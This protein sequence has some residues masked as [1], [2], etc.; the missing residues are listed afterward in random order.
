MP[1]PESRQPSADQANP[2]T[3]PTRVLGLFGLAMINIVAI[4]SLRDLPQMASYGIGSIFFY[5]LAALAFF[6]PVS[7]V[8][9]E[10]ATAW[11][12]RGGVYVWVKKAFGIRWGF[13]AV[14]L[15][16]FQNLCWFPVVLTF[17]AASLAYAVA[18]EHSSELAENKLFI[19]AVI[20]AVYWTSV[21][22][23]FFGLS[24]STRICIMGAI[25]GI[26][27]PGL[28]LI[29]L[30]VIGLLDGAPSRLME[31]SDMLI[32]DLGDFS[33][34]T[35]AV[36]VWLAFAGMEMTA[37]HA[38][39]VRS[40][41]RNYPLAILIS[42]IVILIVFILGALSISIAL[43]PGDY[44]LQS[45]VTEAIQTMLARYGL[46]EWS[47]LAALGMA[48][49]VFGS[50][51]AWIVGPSKGMLASAEDHALPAAL[52]KVNS[53]NVPT[54]I[55]LLQ[56][57][58]VSLLCIAFALQPTVASA[59]FMISVLTIQMYLCM[60]FMMFLSALRLRRRYPEH[61]GSYRV[62]GGKAGLI[63]VCGIGILGAVFAIILGF[64]PPSQLAK[65][66]IDSNSFISFLAIGLALGLALPLAIAWLR[67]LK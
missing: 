19:V 11:P 46:E 1:A 8:A 33:T 34:L 5:I 51:N 48:L 18:P 25:A 3:P 47:R 12:E 58:I 7:L 44:Q 42:G 59:Y 13:L 20:L 37:A 39:E 29:S 52:C 26:F 24:G 65:S 35:F 15:Q 67:G 66:G 6:A 55:L 10:L 41:E 36:S 4:A 32:P 2:A 21:F 60:Y 54:R 28:L 57:G 43:A 56:G 38:R 49:G 23:N 45:G 17:G 63:V 27:I 9:A 62:P 16:W 31:N 14:F 30:A 50:V 53:R 64:F 61:G 22:L 40:P